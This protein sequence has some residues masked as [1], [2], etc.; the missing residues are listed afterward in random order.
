VNRA[1]W[2]GLSTSIAQTATAPAAAA[3]PSSASQRLRSPEK[4]STPTR[5]TQNTIVVPRSGWSSTSMIGIA[6]ATS[7]STTSSPRGRSVPSTGRCSSM[8]S[9][10]ISAGLA[11]SDGWKANPPPSRIH[12]CDPLIVA[13]SGVSTSP[14]VTSDARYASGAYTWSLRASA[15]ATTANST[16]PMT[17]L[18]RCLLTSPV[19]EPA[20]QVRV[21]DQ[22]SRA[23]ITDSSATETSNA[24][25]ICRTADRT[26]SALPAR[27]RRCAATA[28]VM[29]SPY[30]RVR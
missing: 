17:R 30:R 28:R 10:R 3:S 5:I 9:M 4:K 13:P 7:A 18:S 15:V 22:T 11:V 25:S 16:Q 21:E 23:P 19:G 26:L 2:Y 14:S 6:V 20:A 12:E 27:D 29:A 1:T 8:A 24:Q